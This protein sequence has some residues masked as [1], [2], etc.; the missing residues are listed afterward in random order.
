MSL[1]GGRGAA[2]RLRAGQRAAR[3][4]PDGR[5]GRDRRHPRRQR[6]RQDDD[7]AGDLGHDPRQ[8]T[9]TFDGDD[10]T[11]TS[12]EQIVRL[13]IAQVPQG[14]GTFP[15][16]TVEENLR[17]GAYTRKRRRGRP[18]HRPL[19][20]DVPAAGGAAQPA[21][22]QPVGRRA[23]DA[24]HRPGADE[25]AQAAA[26]RRAEPRP[27][28][29]DHQGAVRHHRRPQRALGHRRAARRAE[30]QPRRCRSPT[31]S[32]CSRP[33]ASSPAATPRRSPATTAS[34]RRTWGTE[35]DRFFDALFLGLS[36][37]RSTRSSRSASSSCSAGRAPQ[38]RRR[39]RWRRCRPTSPGS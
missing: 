38:L 7:D 29:A 2:R 14:R 15:E 9:I 5:A 27:R 34:A 4:R 28:A 1:A 11:T 12:P 19:V 10:I 37:G 17:I 3:H 20:R 39:A 13:G 6:G 33:G 8:G 31:A 18:R 25:P 16:L 24:G 22:R 36:A 23:A 30:R 21:G 26:V 32:T 35:M